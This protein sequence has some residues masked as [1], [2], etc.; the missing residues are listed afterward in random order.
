MIYVCVNRE[1]FIDSF[2]EPIKHNYTHGVGRRGFEIE[3][4]RPGG[5]GLSFNLNGPRNNKT[6]TYSNQ[7][8]VG[9][10]NDPYSSNVNK[11]N[12]NSSY[13]QQNKASGTRGE[14]MSNL[15]Y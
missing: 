5:T 11:E 3:N 6:H 4:R 8:I 7:P 2:P 13:K 9:V 1:Q 10:S 14:Y 12:N 15:N